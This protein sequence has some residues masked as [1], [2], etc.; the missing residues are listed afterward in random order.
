MRYDHLFIG[1]DVPNNHEKNV[2]Y[3]CLLTFFTFI[4]FF[5]RNIWFD[6]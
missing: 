3:N 4:A 2:I 6:L 5:V 1:M